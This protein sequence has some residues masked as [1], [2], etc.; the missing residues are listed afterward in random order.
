[1]L[2]SDLDEN[3]FQHVFNMVLFAQCSFHYGLFFQVG[4]DGDR[5][6]LVTCLEKLQHFR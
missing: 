1:M 3:H 6:G 2:C 5:S 4:C